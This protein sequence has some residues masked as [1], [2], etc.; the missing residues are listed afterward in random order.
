MN[1]SKVVNLG[2]AQFK[3]VKLYEPMLENVAVYP[4]DPVLKKE[5]I[6]DIKQDGCN[7][8]RYSVCNHAFHP[9]ADAPKHQ[10]IDMAEIGIESFGM[11]SFFNS[12][13]MI[14]LSSSKRA[15]T[16]NG[17]RYLRQIL[18]EDLESY[19]DLFAEKSSV[20]IR[21]GYDKY[22]ESNQKHIADKI[23]SISLDAAKFMASCNNLNVIAV[24]SLT[25]DDVDSNEIHKLLK[26]KLIVES[27]VHSYNIP[28]RNR[29]E[30]DLQTST[31]SII[32]A[33]GGPV[34][35]FA[36]IRIR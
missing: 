29:K 27:M 14:D 36:Y 8:F 4:G 18:M 28:D 25:V 24:D 33:T 35:A 30:F 7:L 20:I 5:V 11:D 2:G 1:N 34:T 9:H 10:N 16:V 31:V 15:I 13:F 32:G 26:D 12:A 23:P 17:V 6:K 19:K 3:I 21:T 22:I